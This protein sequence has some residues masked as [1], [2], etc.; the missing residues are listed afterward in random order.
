MI[1]GRPHNESSLLSQREAF[2]DILGS[3]QECHFPFSPVALRRRT[4]YFTM[5]DTT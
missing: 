4:R 3:L 5:V 2:G 1:G